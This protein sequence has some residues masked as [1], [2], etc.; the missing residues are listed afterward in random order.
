MIEIL[1]FFVLCVPQNPPPPPEEALETEPVD[2]W[3]LKLLPKRNIYPEYLAAPRQTRTGTKVQFPIETTKGNVTTE[4]VLGT[5]RA[6][7]HWSNPQDPLEEASLLFGAAVFSRFDFEEAWDMDA[8]DYRFGFPFAYRYGEVTGKF[9]FYHITSHLGD[10]HITRT[11]RYR[12]SYHNDELALALSWEPDPAWRFYG[13]IGYPLYMGPTNKGG[14]VEAGAEWRGEPFW[15][16]TF[17]P[18]AAIDLETRNE[19]LWHVNVCALV[20]IATVSTDGGQGMRFFIEYYRG[21]DQQTQFYERREH[22]L[23]LGIGTQL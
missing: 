3:E 16:N 13:E 22:Y 20:G 17:S 23:A 19:I 11:G 2:S 12:K 18:F 21:H 4:N 9:E 8:A 10:E 6:L 1:A 14:R 5:Y 7:A 15:S